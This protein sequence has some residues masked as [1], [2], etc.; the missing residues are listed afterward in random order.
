MRR[1]FATSLFLFSLLCLSTQ[2][3]LAYQNPGA[4]SGFVND[5]TG[6]LSGEEKQT[7]ESKLVAFEK[8]TGN[9]I[10]LAMIASL[11]D[12]TIENFAEA[13]FRE[14]GVGKEGK[15]NGILILI[16]KDDRQMR[17]EVGYGLEGALTDA[18]SFTIIEKVMKPAF[19][20]GDYYGGVSQAIEK[21]I[22]A[23]SGEEIGIEADSTGISSD[24]EI[25]G[26]FSFFILGFMWLVSI[27]GR[28]KSWWFGG[29]I[30]ALIGLFIGFL[31][32]APYYAT[33][34]LLVPLG[35]LLDYIVSK[36]Y[37]AGKSKGNIPWWTGG[38]GFGGG[39]GFGGFGGGRSGGGG[40]SGRW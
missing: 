21:I 31:K 6:T 36:A 3:V 11:G 40:A 17:I 34:I 13:L 24:L 14:W 5:Y 39:G 8:E 25:N 28:S 12:D 1:F 18:Q 35:L 30:G 15:D 32:G 16:A 22:L 37:K 7:L 27:L 4:P 20:A 26:L 2:P 10:A 23:L 19:R 33:M 9:E 29:V 38:S